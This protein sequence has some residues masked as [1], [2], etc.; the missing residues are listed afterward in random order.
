MK[1]S[2]KTGTQR[3]TNQ[4][5]LKRTQTSLAVRRAISDQ[6]LE[7]RTKIQTGG[8]PTESSRA[9]HIDQVRIT[10]H[11]R[12]QPSRWQRIKNWLRNTFGRRSRYPDF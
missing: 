1:K 3:R 10:H 8:M 11:A 12:Y 7:I 6:T 2:K 5:K 4:Q 9:G